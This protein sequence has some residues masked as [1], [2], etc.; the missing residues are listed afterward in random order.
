LFDDIY[1]ELPT[2]D[3]DYKKD[4]LVFSI[5]CCPVSKIPEVT[6]RC[7][8]E[9]TS[10]HFYNCL[11]LEEPIGK[12]NKYVFSYIRA[13]DLTEELFDQVEDIMQIFTPI[14]LCNQ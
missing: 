1:F 12:N 13:H 5:I 9:F 4:G 2:A 7:S 10:G 11:P 8:D 6:K 14:A 3:Q